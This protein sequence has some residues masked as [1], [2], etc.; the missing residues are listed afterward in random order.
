MS[1]RSH[2]QNTDN[3]EAIKAS[4]Q[5][6]LRGDVVWACV[7]KPYIMWPLGA[8]L[9][10]CGVALCAFC[11]PLP[12]LV[13]VELECHPENVSL[14][15]MQEG[16]SQVSRQNQNGKWKL[17]VGSCV[18]VFEAPDCETLT[19]N[20][21]ITP[22]GEVYDDGRM[23]LKIVT[24]PEKRFDFK[25]QVSPSD[26]ILVINGEEFQDVQGSVKLRP[27][28]YEITFLH[29][30]Y[31]LPH[32]KDLIIS[33]DT[34]WEM[35]ELYP[36]EIHHDTS[37]VQ[38]RKIL[39]LFYA[40]P[41]SIREEYKLA[42][43][44]LFDL[45]D[46]EACEKGIC[47]LYI[48]LISQKFNE[49]MEPQRDIMKSSILNHDSPN[50]NMPPKEAQKFTGKNTSITDWAQLKE[51]MEFLV[52]QY[53]GQAD[54]TFWN[55]VCESQLNGYAKAEGIFEQAHLQG[56][57]SPEKIL[58]Q[59]E[60]SLLSH[61]NERTIDLCS[62]MVENQSG[63]ASVNIKSGIMLS[64]L[65]EK[66]QA[67]E[68]FSAAIAHDKANVDAHVLRAVLQYSL[69]H[70]KESI[71]DLDEAEKL[72]SNIPEIFYWR[73]KA[74]WDIFIRENE[75]GTSSKENLNLLDQIIG[76]Y[77][78]VSALTSDSSKWNSS[79]ALENV[80]PPID[81]ATQLVPSGQSLFSGE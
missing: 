41:K 19:C 15:L 55:A 23:P 24:L 78:T 56:N 32:P 25:Y 29:R 48:G 62:K 68:N 16:H 36:G 52:N 27:G 58:F 40:T 57:I 81:H 64:W 50:G 3:S 44:Q 18:L 34:T 8:L 70:L 80:H 71:A 14:S 76:D 38:K 10:V 17:P 6:N 9:L 13:T 51:M 77:S 7:K 74:R 35:I 1:N 47:N 45:G 43:E 53:P 39:F 37:F 12:L 42:F 75:H 65:G 54:F 61:E 21:S 20:V 66:E 4:L 49:L 2:T 33:D 30:Q 59:M 28:K 46:G 5:A 72:N 69:G 31:K 67:V 11:F 60:C 26:A 63:N 79:M 73:A 22:H